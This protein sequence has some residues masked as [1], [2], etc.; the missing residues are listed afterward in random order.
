MREDFSSA[1]DNL[2]AASGGRIWIVSGDRDNA[3][4]RQL[5]EDKL[6]E[7]GLPPDTDP[8]DPRAHEARQWV[9]PPSKS[10]HE[11]GIA[12]DLGGDL[13]LAHQLA[14]Q[15]GLHFPM[16]WE[17]W[18]VEIMGSR[19]EAQEGYTIPPS[20]YQ[21]QSPTSSSGLPDYN[22]ILTSMMGGQVNIFD[23]HQDPQF[24]GISPPTRRLS[25]ERA[26]APTFTTPRGGP[27][28]IDNFMRALRQVESSHNYQAEGVMTD[29]GTAT[30]AYQFLD[31]TWGYYRGY[32]RAKDAPPEIQDERARQLMQEY[33]NK[34]GDWDSV[35]AAWYSG[36]GGNW[37]SGE[38]R[39]YV[40]KVNAN[41]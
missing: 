29:W 39:E 30:G 35:A 15:F 38:V 40:G 17:E 11:K 7:Y 22:A 8:D 41:L 10:N 12:A 16:P 21:S 9:A 23:Y 3:L 13:A 25:P 28:G 2:V 18:H 14:G 27:D 4:Q 36:E 19:D 33:Y 20:G 24:A 34:F 6:A 5:W 26:N 32:A 31:S 37:Q 1:I